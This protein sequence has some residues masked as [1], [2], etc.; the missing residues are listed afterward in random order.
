VVS[1]PE[2][3]RPCDA[4]LTSDVEPQTVTLAKP[5]ATRIAL[6]VYERDEVRVAELGPG[7]SLVIGRAAPADL[8][9]DDLS[10]SRC[11]A[12]ITWQER[13]VLVEDL[14][15]KNGTRVAGQPATQ[16]VAPAGSE[17]LL[18][19]VIVNVGHAI[20]GASLG[21]DDYDRFL[22]RAQDELLRAR[23]YGRSLSMLMFRAHGRERGQLSRWSTRLRAELR[24]IDAMTMYGPTAALVM[25]P[26]LTLAEA[27]QCAQALIRHRA[28][29]P[30]LRCGVSSFPG[31]TSVLE[32]VEAAR[33]SCQ[34]ATLDRPIASSRASSTESGASHSVPI[35]C[36]EQMLDLYRL[37]RRV[38]L[39]SAPVLVLGETGT[40]KEVVA[41]SLHEAGP[42][43]AG[44]FKP[45][46][47]AAI[48]A[49]L[50]ESL[51]FGHEKGAF[52]G[53]H[54]LQKGVFEEAQGGTL[55]LDEI[56][57]LSLQAQ[58][59]LLRVV[60][61]KRIT[62]VGSTREVEI[63]VRIV[64]A[65][66][67]DL[68]AMV[69]AKTFRADLW[70]RLNLVTLTV[71]PLRARQDEIEPLAQRFLEW[72]RKEWHGPARGITV[73]ALDVLRAYPWPGNVR[74]LRN[75]V[76]RA[77][78]IASDE[79]IDVDD[80]PERVR[81]SAASPLPETSLSN[82][83][84]SPAL[85]QKLREYEIQLIRDA[86]VRTGG[87]Q[88]QAARLLEIPLRTLVHKLRVY[89]LRKTDGVG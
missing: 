87:N 89:A 66:H 73:D 9:V 70:H 45:I 61:T 38:G 22:S 77:V 63:D 43:R 31:A 44:P 50:V 5:P 68:E 13:G 20:A 51:L 54:A 59:A 23:S 34:S 47:C 26:E 17:L 1:S 25:L 16:A 60:D 19:N 42:R 88:R 74:E 24:S 78:A 86:L 48:P 7:D 75:V 11:H 6:V 40:G 67:C 58:A 65:T 28:A 32:L 83:R 62:R 35:A 18:G 21:F 2:K 72:A 27:L 37:V 41:R 12:R 84:G 29:E 57:E 3:L 8:V 33:S 36:N 76:E 4:T 52:T 85:A 64:A 30:E 82:G 15:S 71:P 49:P 14:G 79:R 55:F 81:Q 69:A 56:G 46:N 39:G 80:L 10:L 53:A